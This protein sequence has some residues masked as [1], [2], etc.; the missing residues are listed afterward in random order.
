MGVFRPPIGCERRVHGDYSGV[1]V[2]NPA[3]SLVDGEDVWK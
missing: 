1:V 3:S 2:A